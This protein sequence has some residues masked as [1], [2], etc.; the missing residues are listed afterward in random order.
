MKIWHCPECGKKIEPTAIQ[1]LEE[2]IREQQKEATPYE[3]ADTII[4][5]VRCS[6]CNKVY[7]ITFKKVVKYATT[8]FEKI[9]TPEMKL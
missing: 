1:K 7:R 9:L 6:D 2:K 3:N 5:S 4:N 8:A